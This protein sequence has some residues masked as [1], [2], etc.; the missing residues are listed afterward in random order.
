MGDGGVEL[1]HYYQRM[2]DSLLSVVMASFAVVDGRVT[3]TRDGAFRIN[4]NIS[5]VQF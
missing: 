3:W 5:S 2:L 1:P 4:S